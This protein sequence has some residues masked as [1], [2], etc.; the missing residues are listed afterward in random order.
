MKAN[1]QR[2]GNNGF[3]HTV[4]VGQTIETGGKRRR[5]LESAQA[6][7]AVT[8]QELFD[9]RRQVV[10]QVK[11]A[12]N[13]ALDLNGVVKGRTVDDALTLLDERGW[14]SA[15]GDLAT[16]TPV[17]VGL[18]GGGSVPAPAALS[19]E[20]RPCQP[21]SASLAISISASRHQCDLT[22]PCQFPG[23]I[24]YDY[25]DRRREIAFRRVEAV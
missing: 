15:G 5:R 21:Q 19:H 22:Q 12:F 23:G 9:I 10:L 3:K 17:S 25:L 18:P 20:E 24:T 1:A 13:D 4:S 14:V 8:T 7:T 2:V 6:A 11:K 16:T